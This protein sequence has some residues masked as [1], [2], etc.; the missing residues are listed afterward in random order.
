M[1]IIVTAGIVGIIKRPYLPGGIKSII[2]VG[3]VR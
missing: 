1:S 3:Y 2:G